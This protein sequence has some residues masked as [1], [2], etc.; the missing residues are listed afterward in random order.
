MKLNPSPENTEDV[1]TKSF[2]KDTKSKL[3]PRV[4]FVIDH[5]GTDESPKTVL[6]PGAKAS[7]YNKGDFKSPFKQQDKRT[8]MNTRSAI[9]QMLKQY[10]ELPGKPKKAETKTSEQTLQN[11]QSATRSLA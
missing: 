11:I 5:Q 8:S 9:K 4:P 3:T 1:Q 10:T 2:H 6:R 7:F